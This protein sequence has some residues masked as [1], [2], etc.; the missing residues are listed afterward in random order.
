MR[1]LVCCTILAALAAASGPAIQAQSLSRVDLQLGGWFVQTHPGFRPGVVM[2]VTGWTGDHA[3]VAVRSFLVPG[4]YSIH[5]SPRLYGNERGIEVM[6]RYRGRVGNFE[7]DF[8]IGLGYSTIGWTDRAQDGSPTR[9][10]LNWE[11][12]T[13]D[14][15]VGRRLHERFGVKAGV[16]ARCASTEGGS[17]TAMFLVVVPLG[18]L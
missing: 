11:W 1:G 15:L 10:R 2:G 5:R 3:G 16:G 12:L 4:W 8:G 18:S 13:M 14:F 9:R 17:G 6:Y 7:T